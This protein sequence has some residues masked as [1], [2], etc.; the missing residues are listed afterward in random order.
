MG[1]HSQVSAPPQ[2]PQ[3]VNDLPRLKSFLGFLLVMIDLLAIIGAFGLGY[4]ARRRLPILNAPVDPPTFSFYMPILII[5]TL[6]LM[7][8][9]FL[10]RLYHQRRA[11]SRIDQ[12]FLIASSVSIGVVMTNGLTTI[13]L[14]G[15]DIGSDYP[16]QMVVYVWL[17]TVLTVI[18]GREIH[19]LFVIVLRR[20]GL[21]RDRVVIVGSGET[22]QY[23]AQHIYNSRYLGYR[24]IGTIN[25]ADH[26]LLPGI[27]V[28]GT[29][30][31]MPRLIDAYRIDEVIIAVPESPRADLAQLVS[32]CQRGR[33]SI[34]IYPDLFAFMA[35]GMS[36]DDMGGMPLLTVRDIAMR[37]WKLALKRTVDVVGAV[38]GL[39][40]LSP[41]FLLTAILIRLESPG[42]IFFHQ[43]RMGLD[44]RPF[45]MIK[46]RSMRSDAEKSG[47]GW[48]TKN[49]PRVTRMG[50]WM[51]KTNWDEIPNLI[52]VLLGHMSLVGPRP[53][54]V[55]FVQQFRD[56]IPRYMERH[57]EKSGMTGWAQVNG[58]RGDT[59]VEERIKFDLWYVEHWSLGLDIKIL[60]RTVF[61]TILG[62]SK[63]AY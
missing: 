23:I 8:V 52:N 13:L 17:F 5:Q 25:G 1:G 63:N 7:T 10:A 48:T 36:V 38:V 28:I 59:S 32:L 35:G 60:I 40:M 19:R 22:A 39:V 41:L 18:L 56:K 34:K 49:D 62:R 33:V 27:P 21:A 50:K 55:H 15:T 4:F 2:P 24:I 46:F 26:E 30:E 6:T 31:D 57:R 3:R 20:F 9:F 58:L 42:P 29:Q 43:E 61:Q 53:E 12:A 54:Q 45:P 11:V 44:G 37:G 51:R 14:K 47:P 16:R